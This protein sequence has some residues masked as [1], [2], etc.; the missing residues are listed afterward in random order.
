MREEIDTVEYSRLAVKENGL[1]GKGKWYKNISIRLLKASYRY[2]LEQNI[3]F[4][5]TGKSKKAM[6]GMRLRGFNLVQIAPFKTMK[7]GNIIEVAFL[8]WEEFTN[9]G[10]EYNHSFHKW[11]IAE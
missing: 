7:D 6:D 3:R 1:S 8:D 5:Y 11:F 10:R 4:V 2:C 9:N